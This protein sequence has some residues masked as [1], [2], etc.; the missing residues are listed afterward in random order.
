MMK[1]SDELNEKEDEKIETNKI[2]KEKN[3]NL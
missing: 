3:G 2:I 1:S